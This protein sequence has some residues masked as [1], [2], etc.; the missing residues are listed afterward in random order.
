MTSQQIVLQLEALDQQRARW[1]EQSQRDGLSAYKQRRQQLQDRL[2]VTG[3]RLAEI[4]SL[5]SQLPAEDE[6]SILRLMLE[7]DELQPLLQP[8]QAELEEVEKELSDAVPDERVRIEMLEKQL[9]LSSEK[10]MELLQGLAPDLAQ[11]YLHACERYGTPLAEG[12]GGRCQ[13]CR[14]E[15]TDHIQR[16][17]RAGHACIC[18]TCQVV[19]IQNRGSTAR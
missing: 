18:P 16:Q 9:Q 15:L 8:L 17:L 4:D 11:A 7:Q 6:D 13:R 19:V 2:Q 10:R 5:L 12:K 1:L 3:Q 14:L